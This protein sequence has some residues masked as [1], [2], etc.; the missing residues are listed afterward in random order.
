MRLFRGMKGL[1]VCAFLGLVTLTASA[2]SL[3]LNPIP[4]VNQ[5]LVPDAVAPGA[6]GF[7]LTVNGTGFVSG[8]TVDWNG[9]ALTTTFVS[10]SQL[11]ATVPPTN[12]AAAGTAAVTVVNPPL[13]GGRSNV[14][15]LT[16]ANP[17]TSFTFV[18]ATGSLIPVGTSPET[19]AVGDFNGDGKPDLA[20][21][22]SGSNT[23]S[24]LLGNGNGTFT[25]AATSPATGS[26][27]FQAAVGDFNGDGKL[28]LAVANFGSNTLTI[29]L[30]N[31]DGTFTAAASPSTGTSPRFVTA[32]DFNGDGRLDLA[33]ANIGSGTL[34]ILLGNGD[35]TFTAAASPATGS[36]PISIAAGDFNRDGKLDL[37]VLNN[38]SEDLTILLGNGDGTFTPTVSSPTTGLS[39]RSVAVGDFNGDGKLDLAVANQSLGSFPAT[40]LLGNGDGTFT[41][42][43]TPPSSGP[44]PEAVAV[45]DFNGDGKLDLAF[46]DGSQLMVALGDGT[47]NFPETVLAPPGTGS[48]GFSLG[49]GDFNGD[50]RLDLAAIGGS[51][52]VSISLLSLPPSLAPANLNFRS[53]VLSTLSA[54]QTL[55]LTNAQISP[56]TISGIGLGGN[57]SADFSQTNNCPASPATLAPAASCSI[58]VT[59]TPIALG[60]RTAT[61]TVTDDSSFSPQV[62]SLSGIGVNVANLSVTSLDFGN[63]TVNTTSGPRTETLTNFGATTILLTSVVPSGPFAIASN[64]CLSSL[65]PAM[66]CNLTL[67]FTPT[68]LGTQTGSIT[69]TDSAPLSPQVIALTG[70]G[71]AVPL[72]ACPATFQP[73]FAQNYGNLPLSFEANLGQ[74][75][76]QV[77]FLSRG[78][79]YG[80][81]LTPTEA[82]LKL[83]EPGVR[84]QKSGVVSRLRGNDSGQTKD[85]GQG[86]KDSV[87]R[88]QLLNANPGAKV[89]GEDE[90]PGK[91]NYFIGN[92]PA[93]WVKHAPTFVKVRYEQVYPGI[94]LVYYG[95]QRQLEYDF[96][97]APGADPSQISLQL[98]GAGP[99]L[100]KRAP[101]AAPLRIASN[102]DLV[103]GTGGGEVRF[104]KPVVY[105]EQLGVD[106][107]QL[108][109]QDN[110]QLTANHKSPITNHKFLDGRFVLTANNRVSFE[111]ADYDRTQPLIIDPKL[112]YASYLGGSGAD[113]AIGIAVD[114]TCSAYVS[115]GTTSIDFPVSATAS[116]TTLGGTGSSCS[117]DNFDCGDAFVSK[118]SPDG[119]A[120]VYSTYLGGNQDD[121][122]WLIAVD[123]SGD[124]Y[125]AGQ[126]SSTNFPTTVGGRQTALGG[127]RD[128]FLT[129]LSPDGSTLLYST[130]L[131]GSGKD[132]A[133]GVTVDANGNAYIAGRTNSTDFPVTAGAYQTT[134]GDPSCNIGHCGN[135]FVAKFNTNN[136]TPTGAFASLLYSTYLGGNVE[137]EANGI[138]ID[139]AGN[140]YV[141]GRTLSPNF[142][143]VNAYQTTY[144]GGGASCTKSTV[145]GDAFVTELN[146]TATGLVYSTYLGGKGEDTGL[147]ITLD[148]AGAVYVAGGTQSSDFPTTVGAY[149][150]S[151]GGTTLADCSA[152]GFACGDGFIT[153][154]DPTKSGTASLIYSTYLGGANDD[155]AVGIAVDSN[156][157]A[158]VAGITNSYNFPVTQDATQGFFAGG[159]IPCNSGNICGDAFVTKLHP[160]GS[161]LMFSTDLGGSADDGGFGLAL[162]SFGNAYVAGVTASTNLAHNG[163][164][165]QTAFGGGASDA[166]VA[167]IANIK[168]P[169][170][171]L[172]PLVLTFPTQNFGTTS[173]PQTVTLTNIGDAPLIISSILSTYAID[174]A[175]TNT[176]PVSPATLAANANCTISVTFSPSSNGTIFGNLDI[177]DNAAG[178]FQS[179]TMSGTGAAAVVSVTPPSLAFSAQV[180]GTTSAAQPMTLTNVGALPLSITSIVASGDF[181]ETDRCPRSLAVSASCNINVTFTPTGLGARTGAI[182]L[183]DFAPLSPQ[184]FALTGLGVSAAKGSLSPTSLTFAN[185]NV[186]TVSATQAVTLTNTGTGPMGSI[187]ISVTGDFAE[188]DNCPT[189]ASSV[190]AVSAS[191]TINVTF[192]PVHLGALTGQVS[193]FN[194]SLFSP[195]LLALSGTGGPV[196]FAKGE[197]FFSLGN[198]TVL[199]ET[200]TGS[201]IQIMDTGTGS[202]TYGMAFD[203]ARNLYVSDFGGDNVSKFSNTGAPL[204]FF[205]SGYGGGV[206]DVAFNSAGDLIAGS[207][208][209]DNTIRIFDPTGTPLAHYVAAP[210]N[211]GIDWFDLASDQCTLYYTSE[212]SSIKRFDICAG[213]QLTDFVTNLPGSSAYALRFLP[214]GG[215]LVADSADVKR[216][217]ASG[218]IIQSY[219]APGAGELFGLNLDPDGTSF[220]TGDYST[221]DVY[222]FDIASGTL[223]LSFH[224]TDVGGGFGIT[225]NGEITAATDADLSLALN[226]SPNPVTVNNNLTYTLTATNN[227]PNP[228]ANVTVNDTL[229]AGLT[230]VSA[231]PSAGTC[232]GTATV[233]CSLGTLANAAAATVALV[234]VPT[235]LGTISN[236]ASVTSDAADPNPA[237]NTATVSS[238][239][240]P[241]IPVAGLSS[242]SLTFPGQVVGTTSAVQTVTLTNSGTGTLTITSIVPSGDFAV[243][244]TC[245]GSV[246]VS[247]SC[248]FSVTF[249]PTAL[250]AR[251][252]SIIITDN[253]SPTTQTITLSGTGTTAAQLTLSS[254]RL[255]LPGTHINQTCTPGVV[256][257]TNTGTVPLTISNISIVAGPYTQTNTC[258]A[259]LAPGA[260]CTV[261]VT[262]VPTVVAAAQAGTLSIASNAP[263][264]PSTVALSA[265]GLAACFLAPNSAAAA[266]LRGLNTTTF[267]IA[268]QACSAAGAVHL[269]CSNQSPATCAFS[270]DTLTSPD[271][272]STLTVSNLQALTSDLKFE[273]HADA[274]L[275]HLYTGLAVDLMD[276]QMASA[277][278]TGTINAGETASYALAVAPQNGLQGTVTFTCQGA[279]A[280]AT[281]SVTPPAVTLN[282]SG[283]S[284]VTVKVSTTARSLTLPQRWKMLPPGGSPMGLMLLAALGLMATLVTWPRAGRKTRGWSAIRWRAA[285]LAAGLLVAMVLTWAACGG[286]SVAPVASSVNATPSGTYTLTVTGTYTATGSSVQ[287]THDSTLTLTVH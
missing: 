94:D 183:T 176:C 226:V 56:L 103:I 145:C 196:P 275:E 165:Y 79:G 126:T 186:G 120:L 12:V 110:G 75:D 156:G 261:S 206:E 102:G 32:G 105:Q 70:I 230:F 140:A 127:L 209:G 201:L 220:W 93:K 232:T 190:L 107:S 30:G 157:S 27:P 10:N 243:T 91:S 260:S 134:L 177:Y 113:A 213:T 203:S 170:V 53:Q 246:A 279:P 258:P 24:I 245:G 149:Q 214:S 168:V 96:E 89:T 178:G 141:T 233:T 95:N 50:G 235:A 268:H 92:D 138:A 2:Q 280:G 57:D 111:V 34:T 46:D 85:K 139:A 55:T 267:I 200:S 237:N 202:Y 15:F 16:I 287:I 148:A 49:V 61:L 181:A 251:S 187:V 19:V 253:A 78:N 125:I 278:A 159:T 191:C 76:P 167:R 155:I 90:L 82:V 276:F 136:T 216:L 72:S 60:N 37:A 222:K 108:T 147:G 13:G 100:P 223:L 31:G 86:T 189:T 175:E 114:S 48:A 71:V 236:T 122:A 28:D 104:K 118:L 8:A 39:P 43:A 171:N 188:T 38:V 150:A 123:A 69:F 68:T 194:D 5:P 81:F 208:D 3:I 47:G 283:V 109:G 133:V 42:T 152:S 131:G 41:A 25:A 62:A 87:L 219:V 160:T 269:S 35:G 252:G 135:A 101:Q 198:G 169:L 161:V 173:A 265:D 74:T 240:A 229:P 242:T 51:N 116:Q 284:N 234:V 221:A 182:T 88:M 137:D 64:N 256:T 36:N 154:I 254:T 273:V 121:T 174:F 21:P 115:G 128:A 179:V 146:S 65:A 210:Q 228:A 66:S 285:T 22:N 255:V 29:L 67:T 98:A 248:N 9:V 1:A 282:G 215:L 238:V 130:Y 281:C 263:G 142:P 143:T 231:T 58:N 112:S 262:F 106:S 119:T 52:N 227:G 241:A 7:T 180:L 218:N 264:S 286:G 45:G 97:V 184:A 99:A 197:L 162:D 207:V 212:G 151:F 244:N 185:Q 271:M 124:A 44:Y 225:V 250:G 73:A 11:T 172:S 84:S 211:R 80:L 83:Q 204:G 217:D 163:T 277:A 54:V 193:I 153:K 14:V 164:E 20:V 132:N 40:I 18:N 166:F 249:T 257:A 59:F 195:V 26:T 272:P 158:H 17:A 192:N 6:A 259:T 117:I 239:V 23:I 144:S 129:R 205:G 224:V 247:G 63:Q 4:F 266:V 270:P 199:R 33:V 77:K 274:A